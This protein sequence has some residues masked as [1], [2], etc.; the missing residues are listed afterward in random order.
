MSLTRSTPEWFFFLTY[1]PSIHQFGTNQFSLLCIIPPTNKQTDISV[2][3][4][5]ANYLD[6][7]LIMAKNNQ[8]TKDPDNYTT[9]IH[10]THKDEGN[11]ISQFARQMNCGWPQLHPSN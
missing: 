10:K 2:G 5:K 11:L 4:D 8:V 1:V 9:H 7:Y 6:I 3:L